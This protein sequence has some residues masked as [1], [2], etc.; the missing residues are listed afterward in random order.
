MG[1]RPEDGDP[2]RGRRHTSQDVE[3]NV[4]KSRAS[5]RHNVTIVHLHLGWSMN[6][7]ELGE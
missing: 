4:L 7:E 3:E 2:R 5:R 6:I 1:C